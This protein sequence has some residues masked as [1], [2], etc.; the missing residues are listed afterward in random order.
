MDLPEGLTARPLVMSDARAVYDVMAAQE[1]ADLGMVEIEEADIVSDW[2]RPSFDVSAQGVGVFDGDRLVGYAEFARP[3]RGDAAVDPSYRGRGI[4]TA[5]AAW[6]REKAASFGATVVGMPVPEGSP[7]DRLL[8]GLGYEVRWSSWVLQLPEGADIV[9]RPLP[10][11]YAVREA[12]PSE[13]P[14]VHTV[15]EDAFLEWSVRDRETFDDFRAVVM[16]RPGFEP[17][18]VR[19]VTDPAGE[20]VGVAIESIYVPDDDRPAEAFVSRLAVRRDQRNRGLAQALMVDAFR[21]ARD[22]G[23][24]T[25]GLSTDSRTGALGLYEKVG[26]KVTSTWV[27]RAISV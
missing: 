23:A 26:M 15:V 24:V 8:A 13:Y 5:L 17:W 12:D 7:S 22:H 14:A 18:M 9:D 3:D 2:A 6:M 20:V 11:G 16:G 1:L 19:V 21:V 27:N 25:C 10:D 4:G